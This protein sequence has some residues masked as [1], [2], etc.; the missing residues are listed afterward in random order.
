MN[1][2]VVYICSDVRS[3]STLLDM[4]L[5]RHPL[6]ASVGE[7]HHLHDYL[8]GTYYRQKTKEDKCTCGK[9]L[10]ECSFWNKIIVQY[11]S[12]YNKDAKSIPTK[13]PVYLS[14]I[15]QFFFDFFIA[16]IHVNKLK[17]K[18]SKKNKYAEYSIVTD[19]KFKIYSVIN[20]V[21]K[22]SFVVDSSK[23][24]EGLKFLLARSKQPVK[25]I[26]LTR[27]LRA[28]AY[29]KFKRKAG[30][31]LSFVMLLTMLFHIRLF[32]AIKTV[33]RHQRLIVKYEDMVADP[34]KIMKRIF[35]FLGLNNSSEIDIESY[36][37]SHVI[38]GSPHRLSNRNLKIFTDDRWK[39]NIS[40]FLKPLSAV[41]VLI[42][43]I[44]SIKA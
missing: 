39:Q 17:K 31:R 41:L 28:I 36:Y 14:S 13:L 12:D 37:E 24:I 11:K 9:T 43:K 26:F 25:T 18:I 2:N 21:H 19:N 6:I 34:K 40:F 29:S 32:L 35:L 22:T 5:G 16:A 20:D 42:Q 3:G 10:Y 38:G 33:P 1:T 7:L 27:D 30:S 8:N 15:R 4:L 23:K 44:F